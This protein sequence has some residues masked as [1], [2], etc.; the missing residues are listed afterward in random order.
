M[1]MY[2]SYIKMFVSY[3]VFCLSKKIHTL[4]SSLLC[5]LFDQESHDEDTELEEM[6]QH[7]VKCLEEHMLHEKFYKKAEESQK[8]FL[9]GLIFQHCPVYT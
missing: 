1:Y 4:C 5:F 6:A 8:K 7:I 9:V 2:I 3:P